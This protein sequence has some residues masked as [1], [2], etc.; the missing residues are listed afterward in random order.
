MLIRSQAC[1]SF[2]VTWAGF[3]GCKGIHLAC[4]AWNGQQPGP[5][6]SVLSLALEHQSRRGS[7]EDSGQTQFGGQGAWGWGWGWG[8]RHSQ[9][10]VWAPGGAAEPATALPPPPPSSAKKHEE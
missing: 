2:H 4:K 1:G 6:Q 8:Q 5:L 9:G 7:E 10:S 3:R